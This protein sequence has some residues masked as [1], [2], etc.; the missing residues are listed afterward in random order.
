MDIQDNSTMPWQFRLATLFTNKLTPPQ[1]DIRDP[2]W[3][4]GDDSIHSKDNN[5]VVRLR[6][7]DDP[8]MQNRQ[9]IIAAAGSQAGIIIKGNDSLPDRSCVMS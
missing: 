7:Y 9:E 1:I 5:V 3:R 6:S 4:K 8:E 2:L